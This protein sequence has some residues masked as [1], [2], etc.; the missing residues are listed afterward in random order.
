MLPDNLELIGPAAGVEA[1]LVGVLH[2]LP[3]LF[4]PAGCPCS[5]SDAAQPETKELLRTG[6]SP[7]PQVH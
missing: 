2:P 6:L 4:R 3:L 7:R 1:T 5:W